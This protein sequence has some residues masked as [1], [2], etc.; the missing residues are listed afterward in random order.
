MVDC[1][2]SSYGCDGGFENM[3]ISWAAK[4]GIKL[5]SAY[6]YVAKN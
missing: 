4:N 6:P 3:A 1:D 5:G 2:K